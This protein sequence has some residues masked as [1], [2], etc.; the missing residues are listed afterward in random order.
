MQARC[1]LRA[2][3]APPDRGD[4]RQ[5]GGVTPRF[6]SYD[7]LRGGIFPN[8]RSQCCVFIRFT[9]SLDLDPQSFALFG[10]RHRGLFLSDPGWVT[11]SSLTSDVVL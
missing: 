11:Q 10:Y 7:L 4:R 1:V 5:R 2:M 6:H 9:S 8:G 3:R